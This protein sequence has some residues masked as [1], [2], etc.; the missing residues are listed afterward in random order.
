MAKFAY[1][2]AEL[3]TAFTSDV[4]H[5]SLGINLHRAGG[6]HVPSRPVRKV[7]KGFRAVVHLLPPTSLRG[8]GSARMQVVRAKEEFWAYP[9]EGSHRACSSFIWNRLPWAMEASA[10]VTTPQLL[11][12]WRRVH[13]HNLDSSTSL[14]LAG[15]IQSLYQ[16]RRTQSYRIPESPPRP[17][18]LEPHQIN[19]HT[20]IIYHEDSPSEL[21]VSGGHDRSHQ[22]LHSKQKRERRKPS[23]DASLH[24]DDVSPESADSSVEKRFWC[25]S[26]FWMILAI[27]EEAMNNRHGV[28]GRSHMGTTWGAAH[29]TY[30]HAFTGQQPMS[31]T[32]NIQTAMSFGP[33]AKTKEIPQARPYARRSVI[34]AAPNWRHHPPGPPPQELEVSELVQECL[35]ICSFAYRRSSC[36]SVMASVALIADRGALIPIESR[37]ERDAGGLSK[38]ELSLMWC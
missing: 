31:G 23:F 12:S 19:K 18:A 37:R 27:R 21:R 25:L 14:G 34:T 22:L 35:G 5:L 28:D 26:G 15:L 9:R 16:D 4:G 24:L 3:F 13:L 6:E 38:Q 20:K 2:V 8:I 10:F 29:S 36:G 11:E 17:S 33:L 7:P 1:K 30:E 32:Y